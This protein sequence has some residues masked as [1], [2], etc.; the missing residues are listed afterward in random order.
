M[1]ETKILRKEVYATKIYYKEV[2]GLKFITMKCMKLNVWYVWHTG[3][4]CINTLD[5][6]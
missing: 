2:Y 3:L 1:Y 4:N 5:I 6:R